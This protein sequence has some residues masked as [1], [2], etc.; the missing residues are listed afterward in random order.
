MEEGGDGNAGGE[1]GG[2]P[3]WNGFN[4]KGWF[5]SS[6]FFLKFFLLVLILI[7]L[8]LLVRHEGGGNIGG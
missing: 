6:S 3:R 2:W 4:K 8:C 7:L 5:V 1:S